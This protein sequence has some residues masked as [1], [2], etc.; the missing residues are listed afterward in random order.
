MRL[1]ALP[2]L[3]LLHLAN[4]SRREGQEIPESV[5]KNCAWL[6]KMEL[7]FQLLFV[8][9]AAAA[10]IIDFFDEPKPYLRAATVAVLAM[11]AVTVAVLWYVKMRFD[12]AM[13]TAGVAPEAGE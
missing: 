10:F 4:Q 3:L 6:A 9:A 12:A 13:G 2:M 5:M 7:F 11:F 8:L 1:V